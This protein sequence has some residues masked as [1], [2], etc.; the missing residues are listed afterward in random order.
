VWKIP[1]LFEREPNSKRNVIDKV[2]PEC[3]WVMY[4]YG[5]ATVKFDGTA[6]IYWWLQ[7]DMKPILCK[8]MHVKEGD[9]APSEWKHWSGVRSSHG[10]GWVPI[11]DGPEDRWHREGQN[12]TTPDPLSTT[13]ELVGPKI[14]SNP[15]RLEHHE[16]WRHDSEVIT[17]EPKRDYNSI[18]T[19]L[20]TAGIEGIV[21][22]HKDGRMAKIKSRDFGIDW[23]GVRRKLK[24]E[25][26]N[27]S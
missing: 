19:Y 13:Y 22:H 12:N 16:L 25:G 4:G 26:A 17:L 9:E 23:V 8:R 15:Y 5:D 2:N 24:T 27:I 11:G 6:C 14:Q 20:E 18:K 3:E 10:H 7:G 21:Y 1:S